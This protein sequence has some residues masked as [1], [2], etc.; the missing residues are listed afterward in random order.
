[1]PPSTP[2]PGF[3]SADAGLAGAEHSEGAVLTAA[4]V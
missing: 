4:E 2:M 3:Q 1:M